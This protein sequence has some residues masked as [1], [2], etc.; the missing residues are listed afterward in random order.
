MKDITYNYSNLDRFLD[1]NK[2][3]TGVVMYN[4][5]SR[6][7]CTQYPCA[8]ETYCCNRLHGQTQDQ[9]R[10]LRPGVGPFTSSP[11]VLNQRFREPQP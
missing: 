9:G 8:V 7:S 5:I 11:T 10:I 3:E 2:V 6:M 4:V 1:Y